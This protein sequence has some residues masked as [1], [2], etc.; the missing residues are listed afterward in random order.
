MDLPIGHQDL[1]IF[2]PGHVKSKVHGDKPWTTVNALI[3][4]E[5]RACHLRHSTRNDRE[6]SLTIGWIE[7]S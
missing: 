7:P 3:G 4:G 6:N 1:A 2:H 5:Y